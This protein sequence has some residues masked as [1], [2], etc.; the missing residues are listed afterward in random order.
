MLF[1]LSLI[2]DHFFYARRDRRVS[3]YA[4]SPIVHGVIIAT[5]FLLGY[6]VLTLVRLGLLAFLDVGPTEFL[7]KLAFR[8]GTVA[9]NG[10]AVTFADVI[11]R[12]W[13]VG[14]QLT[15]GGAEPATWVM[16]FAL[17]AWIF[18]LFA[19]LAALWRG[20][21]IRARFAVDLLVLVTAA[22][23]TI[24]WY[25]LLPGHTYTDALFA[26]RT[27]ALS[28]GC[29]IA[30]ALLVSRHVISSALPKLWIPAIA[31]TSAVMAFVL[32]GERWGEGLGLRVTMAKVIVAPVDDLVSCAPVGLRSDGQID[33]VVRTALHKG[34][35]SHGITPY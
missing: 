5:C 35:V 25:A 29:G 28:A 3:T 21:E 34:T 32:I 33:G 26:V 22:A 27:I 16:F 23:G 15:L 4:S 20:C 14:F 18:T 24:V 12:L 7:S 30:A 1:G 19:F 8:L 17:S 13:N 31:S 9:D 10:T 6:A 2:A 11:E